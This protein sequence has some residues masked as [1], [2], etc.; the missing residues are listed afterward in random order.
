MLITTPAPII[1]LL[2]V[3]SDL[4]RGFLNFAA[5]ASDTFVR[6]CVS[7]ASFMPWCVIA[8]GVQAVKSRLQ[9]GPLGPLQR[10][11]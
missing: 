10:H 5:G 3:N 9:P 11:C 4:K 8:G 2:A 6:L 7:G 1:V